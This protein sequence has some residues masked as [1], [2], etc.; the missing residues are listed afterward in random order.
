MKIHMCTNLNAGLYAFGFLGS[1]EEFELAIALQ[2]C[3]FPKITQSNNCCDCA[4]V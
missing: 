3:G 2:V 4:C 1:D